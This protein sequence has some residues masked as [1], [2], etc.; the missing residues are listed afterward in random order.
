MKLYCSSPG[1]W[2][3]D[4]SPYCPSAGDP[5]CTMAGHFGGY[6][7]EWCRKGSQCPSGTF[8]VGFDQK[9]EPEQGFDGD[10]TALNDIAALCSDGT[11]IKPA[12]NQAEYGTYVT[13]SSFSTNL[14]I[15]LTSDGARGPRSGSG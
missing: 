5:T 8:I 14:R 9:V 15:A 12:C 7:G 4:A 1:W 2:D 6:W 13:V 11:V 3:L 10:D